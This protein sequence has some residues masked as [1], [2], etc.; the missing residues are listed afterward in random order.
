MAAARAQA[1]LLLLDTPDATSPLDCDA[2][3]L[4]RG[5]DILGFRSLAKLYV[6]LHAKDEEAKYTLHYG[7]Q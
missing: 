7:V 6:A 2:G 5:G 1:I 3:N 4:V